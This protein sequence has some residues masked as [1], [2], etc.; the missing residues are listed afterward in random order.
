[1]KAY[2]KPKSHRNLEKLQRKKLEIINANTNGYKEDKIALANDEIAE[3]LHD[4]HAKQFEKDVNCLENLK[5]NKGKSAA[6][7]KLHEKLL[8]NKKN[9]TRTDQCNG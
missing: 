9:R 7:F 2:S 4:I 3:I 1:M 5:R 6:V 8:G